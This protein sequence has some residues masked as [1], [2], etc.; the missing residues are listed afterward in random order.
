MIM[1]ELM[2][3]LLHLLMC[4]DAVVLSAARGKLWHDKP[5]ALGPLKVT[6]AVTA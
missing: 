4:R 6:A 2:V 3:L 1:W 5:T